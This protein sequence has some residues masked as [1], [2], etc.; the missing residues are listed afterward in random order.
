[1]EISEIS[2][3]DPNPTTFSDGFGGNGGTNGTFWLRNPV[4]H[5]GVGGVGSCLARTLYGPGANQIT[6]GDCVTDAE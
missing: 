2:W 6:T 5:P 4:V 1:M 3:N